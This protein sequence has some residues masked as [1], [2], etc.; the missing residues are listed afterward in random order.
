MLAQSM[1]RLGDRDAATRHGVF[2]MTACWKETCAIVCGSE[3]TRLNLSVVKSQ[4]GG[5]LPPLVGWKSAGK[6]TFQP[7]NPQP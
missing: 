5:C 2:D 3:L 1:R 7:A 4:L 6:P